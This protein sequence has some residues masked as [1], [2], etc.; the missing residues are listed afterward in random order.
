VKRELG[1][2]GI[3]NSPVIMGLWQAGHKYWVGIEDSEIERAIGAALD[4]GITT[5]DTAEVYGDGHSER[6]L[7]KGLG[8]RRNEA[9]ILTKVF[10][11]HMRRDQVIAACEG[12]LSRLNTDRIDLYQIHWP[13]GS[14]GSDIVPVGETMDALLRLK[15]QGKIRAIGVSNFSVPQL[16]EASDHGR[17]ESVQPPYSLF[18]RF[19]ENEIQPWCVENSVSILSYSPLA[20]GILAG[21]FGPQPH[22]EDGD[23]RTDNKLFDPDHYPKVQTALHQLR[24]IALR[25]QMT[26]AQLSLAWLISQPMTSAVAGVRNEIQIID[27]AKAMSATLSDEDLAEIGAIGA[28]VAEPF[29][30]DTVPWTWNP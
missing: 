13:S 23:H 17:I 8:D 24:P 9:L 12:S 10:A 30:E 4:H 22:F 27:N 2:S 11:N 29:M 3:E 7:A 19:V 5:F 14:W 20:Q 21:K 28:R 16:E 1:I 26:L 18:W 25:N 15:E 6:M